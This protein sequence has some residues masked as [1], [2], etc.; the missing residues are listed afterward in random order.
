MKYNNARLRRR[1]S[2][3]LLNAKERS[4]TFGWLSS[5]AAF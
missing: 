3:T 1:Q 5:I 2:T 4:I